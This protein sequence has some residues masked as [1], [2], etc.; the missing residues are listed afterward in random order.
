M[1]GKNM[2]ADEEGNIFFEEYSILPLCFKFGR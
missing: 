2:R 1:D